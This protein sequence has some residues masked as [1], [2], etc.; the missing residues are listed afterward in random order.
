MKTAT[1]LFHAEL[2][3]FLPQDKRGVSFSYLFKGN[4]AIKDSLEANGVPHVEIDLIIINGSSVD[5]SYQ[6]QARDSVSICPDGKKVNIT[7][8]IRL[9]TDLLE[10]LSLPADEEHK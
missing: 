9:P 10:G 5:F 4:P 8:V 3:D 2:N 1:F 7:P 6:L